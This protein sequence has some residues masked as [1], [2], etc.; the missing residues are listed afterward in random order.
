MN[1]ELKRGNINALLADLAE[2]VSFELKEANIEITLN[3]AEKLPFVD[4]DERLMKQAFLNLI[5]N[6]SAAMIGGGKLS[7]SSGVLEG[8]IAIAVADSGDGISEGNLPKVFEPFFTTRDSG[9]GLGLTLV[10][11][12]IRE[13][14]GEI[15]VESRIGEGTVFTVLLPMPQTDRRLISYRTDFK[16]GRNP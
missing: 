5:K 10:Y 16:N 11:K 9:S 6:A 14:S 2:F 4:F 15:S 3:L 12:I 8:E 1:A 13:H 7:I